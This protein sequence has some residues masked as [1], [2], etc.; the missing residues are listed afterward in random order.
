MPRR[1]P[2]STSILLEIRLLRAQPIQAEL[3]RIL[4]DLGAWDALEM[5]RAQRPRLLT[6]G[7]KAVNGI[8]PKPWVGGVIWQRGS[9]YTGYRTLLIAGIWAQQI[10]GGCLMSVGQKV[11]PY[12]APFY[13][14]EAYHKLIRAGFDVYYRDDGSPPPPASRRLEVI[15]DPETRPALR[16]KIRSALFS[17]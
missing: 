14:A 6:W 13:E 17:L 12:A 8:V 7:P 11:V 1:R 5:A 2:N 16:D 10:D 3:A 9:G 15:Y 4:D